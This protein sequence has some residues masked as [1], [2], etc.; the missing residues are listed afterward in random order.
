MQC[1]D[2]D[3]EL[4]S[5]RLD[6]IELDEC[7]GCRGWWLDPVD[8]STLAAADI[9]PPREASYAR[10]TR[11]PGGLS[12]RCPRCATDSLEFGE[13]AGVGAALC[14]GCRGV[15]FS[16]DQIRRL[17][18]LQQG[19]GQFRVMDLISALLLFTPVGD[20]PSSD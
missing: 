20:L 2:C 13:I 15:F 3:G 12:W 4:I 8:L 7:S 16:A 10:F 1:P 18:G 19:D 5:I 14:A 6:E 9:R 11:H 17:R